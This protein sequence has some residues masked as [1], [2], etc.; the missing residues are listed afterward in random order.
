MVVV[1]V[2]VVLNVVLLLLLFVALALLRTPKAERARATK[3]VA[4]TDTAAAA[5]SSSSS[6][7]PRALE[8]SG[9]AQH[10]PD[11]V[12]V[13]STAPVTST[14]LTPPAERAERVDVEPLPA[15]SR[16]GTNGSTSNGNGTAAY[17]GDRIERGSAELFLVDRPAEL[18]RPSYIRL[19]AGLDGDQQARDELLCGVVAQLAPLGFSK[20][21]VTGTHC[22]LATS[23]GRTAA[24]STGRLGTGE[25]RIELVV[26]HVLAPDVL[27]ELRRWH[28]VELNKSDRVQI[29]ALIR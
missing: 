13:T 3:E 14:T 28:R 9:P 7:T 8:T 12:P 5:G 24:I 1:A 18:H 26:D 21:D 17:H 10:G 19:I 4:S 23:E 29:S 22:R 25:D 16:A 15:A 2:F 20:K 6:R 11:L 27:T